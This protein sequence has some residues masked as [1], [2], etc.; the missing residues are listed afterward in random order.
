MDY[1]DTVK[2]AFYIATRYRSLWIF[3]VLLALCGGS[4]FEGSSSSGGG[5]NNGQFMTDIPP[6]AFVGLICLGLLLL[7]IGLFVYYFCLS[8][9]IGMVVQIEDTDNVTIRDWFRIGWSKKSLR[10]F[11][12]SLV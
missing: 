7:A 10:T 2:R 4:G 3:G 6:F 9:I 8:T 1:R 5:A 11:L 12:I